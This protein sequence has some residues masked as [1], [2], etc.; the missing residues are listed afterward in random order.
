MLSKKVNIHYSM[1]I[2]CNLPEVTSFNIVL[3][4]EELAINQKLTV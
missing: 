4:F 3:I 1:A 2:E